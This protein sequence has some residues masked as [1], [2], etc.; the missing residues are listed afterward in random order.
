MRSKVLLAW[1]GNTDLKAEEGAASAGVGPIAQVVAAQKYDRVVLLSNFSGEAGNRYKAWLKKQTGTA[2]E[3]KACRLS[4]PTN[5]GEIYEAVVE[6]LEELSAKSSGEAEFT[7][8]LSPGTPAM[9]SVWIILAKTRYPATLI[10]SSREHGVKVAAVPFDISAD[11]LPNLLRKPDEALIRLTQGLP[12]EAPEFESIVHR[13]AFMSEVI[14]RARRVAVRTLPVLIEGESG[15][16]KELMARAIHRSSSRRER[17]FVAVNCGAIPAELVESEF[18]G[19]KKGAFTGAT[20]D[21]AG[22]FEAAN[23]GTLFLDEIGE[24][25]KLIQVKLLRVLET[26]EVVR[27]GESNPRKVDVRI[28]SATNRSLADE[29]RV[30][31][32]RE[33]LYYRL[34]VAILKLPALRNRS[35]DVSL[36]I[37]SSLALINKEAVSEPGYK[38][39]KLS[40]GARNLMLQHAWPGNVRELLNTLRRAAVWSAEEVI[41]SA[42]IRE[43]I[44]DA[45]LGSKTGDPILGRDIEQGVDLQEIMGDVA[46]HYLRRALEK[47]GGSKT[48][49]AEM[50]G[51]KNYQTFSN[52][53]QKYDQEN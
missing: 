50:L 14:A 20:A 52:W 18:F 31:T 33:D 26:G 28:I 9:A 34:A 6:V 43:S 47:S 15:T 30:G 35:G 8:H 21:R 48:K 24:L 10:E 4:G 37:D 12:A 41:S 5:F 7:F 2:C 17:P 46:R 40:P 22:H 45:K 27:V 49:A 13:S 3:I 53:L 32:F 11:Y 36:I 44:L 42:T 16:G 38:P 29:I 23:A 51:F 1:I 39:K 25:P 19:H